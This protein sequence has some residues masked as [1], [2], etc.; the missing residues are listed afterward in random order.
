[1][2][3]AWLLWFRPDL[4]CEDLGLRSLCLVAHTLPCPS[5][6]AYST[7]AS[8]LPSSLIVTTEEY[9][10]EEALDEDAGTRPLPASQTP[11]NVCPGPAVRGALQSRGPEWRSPCASWRGRCGPGT[12]QPSSS[13]MNSAGRRRRRMC[14]CRC[15]SSLVRHLSPTGSGARWRSWPALLCELLQRLLLLVCRLRWRPW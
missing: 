8:L 13:S 11:G 1:M 15:P 5:A 6:D 4:V 12:S 9:N 2:V 14:P 10:G 7:R 3:S